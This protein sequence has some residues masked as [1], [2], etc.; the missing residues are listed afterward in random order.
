M[1]QGK[2]GLCFAGLFKLKLIRHLRQ[3][4]GLNLEAVDLVTRYRDRIRTMQRRLDEM[5]QRMRQ[6]EQKCHAEILRHRRQPA[7]R[8]GRD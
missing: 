4:M 2:Q 1:L 8:L 7:Q 3:D 5:G 6:K